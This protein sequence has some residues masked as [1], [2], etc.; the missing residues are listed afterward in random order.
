MKRHQKR[1]TKRKKEKKNKPHQVQLFFAFTA[2]PANDIFGSEKNIE[3]NIVKK[4]P[5]VQSIVFAP[6]PQSLY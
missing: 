1:R 5:S 2:L 6:S 3:K 4:N